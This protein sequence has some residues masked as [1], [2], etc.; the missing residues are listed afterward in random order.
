MLVVSGTLL[1][2]EVA[3][4]RAQARAGASN[5]G[6][7]QSKLIRDLFSLSEGLPQGTC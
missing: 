6:E 3:D 7:Q 2:T 4:S 5:T 1:S